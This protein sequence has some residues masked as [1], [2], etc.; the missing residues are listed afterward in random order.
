MNGMYRCEPLNVLIQLKP[1]Y[2]K[3][4]AAPDIERLGYE[5]SYKAMWDMFPGWKM[6]G[7]LPILDREVFIEKLGALVYADFEEYCNT[8]DA[9]GEPVGAIDKWWKEWF[10]G[11]VT[12]GHE[13]YF[14]GPYVRYE[15][16]L[17]HA[18][19]RVSGGYLRVYDADTDEKRLVKWKGVV[20]LEEN[21]R[22]QVWMN[23]EVCWVENPH[24]PTLVVTK[25]DSSVVTVPREQVEFCADKPVGTRATYRGREVWFKWTT[26]PYALIFD[27]L[28]GVDRKVSIK[29][30]RFPPTATSAP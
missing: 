30:L 25:P 3:G 5:K 19:G 4:I 2:T 8:A 21:K 18:Q 23:G 27:P 14:F 7:M 29:S 12:P 11:S 15:D 20:Y 28:I 6:N 24:G 26:K 13:H 1:E 17:Y 9:T 16:K 10:R 22:N